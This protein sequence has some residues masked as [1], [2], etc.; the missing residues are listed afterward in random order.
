MKKFVSIV[1]C[2]FLS[3]SLFGCS[4]KERTTSGESVSKESAS[5]KSTVYLGTWSIEEKP[6]GAPLG[7][8]GNIELND[9]IGRELIFS[10]K[11]ASC[12]G[13]NIDTLGQYV[14]NPEYKEMNIPRSDFEQTTGVAFDALGIESD[15]ILQIVVTK[16]PERNTGIVFYIVDNDK[17]LV[18]GAG[19]FLFLKRVDTSSGKNDTGSETAKDDYS[20]EGKGADTQD[21]TTFFS[22]AYPVT[23]KYPASMRID[24]IQNNNTIQLTNKR[25]DAFFIRC[26]QK[27]LKDSIKIGLNDQE[28]TESF[29]K[30][31]LDN[32]K[33]GAHDVISNYEESSSQYGDGSVLTEAVFNAQT[34]S[35]Y[36]K[37]RIQVMVANDYL[38]A[39]QVWSDVEGY[40]NAVK[41]MDSILEGMTFTE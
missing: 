28:T 9:I 29:I 11:I 14:D 16:D 31:T 33:N 41:E 30:I 17:L 39:A 12:F 8:F 22:P 4:G 15:N 40:E 5:E 13:D 21:A 20:V 7:D 34:S 3:M 18:N 32:L 1:L 6:E 38:I 27:F 25:N 2:I 24:L 23:F 26:E 37:V 19:T 36:W 35:G 10:E